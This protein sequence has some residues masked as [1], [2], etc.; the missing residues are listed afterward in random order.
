MA[1]SATLTTF[2][3]SLVVFGNAKN[4]LRVGLPDFCLKLLSFYAHERL[5]QMGPLLSFQYRKLAKMLSWKVV[6][7]SILMGVAYFVHGNMSVALKLGPAD[8]TIKFGIYY[9]HD[10]VWDSI[11]CFDDASRKKEVL[12]LLLLLLLLSKIK[13]QDDKIA[14]IQHLNYRF[15]LKI[16]L[17]SP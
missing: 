9:I 11:R 5:W 1:R 15:L 14:S 16:Y 7:V 4:A 8:A 10:A 6:A 2:V 3:L 13:K 12:L 17:L